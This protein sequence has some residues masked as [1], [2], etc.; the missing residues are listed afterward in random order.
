MRDVDPIRASK[1]TVNDR[2]RGDAALDL[3]NCF[4]DGEFIC[5]A[6]EGK[7]DQLTKLKRELISL[8]RDTPY[9]SSFIDPETNEIYCKIPPHKDL[10]YFEIFNERTLHVLVANSYF[11]E[12]SPFGNYI[13][14]TL[15]ES[16]SKDGQGS[17][18]LNYEGQEFKS[19]CSINIPSNLKIYND[20]HPSFF[21]FNLVDSKFKVEKIIYKNKSIELNKIYNNYCAIYPKFR[22]D[23]FVSNNI[24]FKYYTINKFVG[25]KS[26]LDWK[27]NK[28]EEHHVKIRSHIENKSTFDFIGV[29]F[30]ERLF[31]K[32]RNDENFDKT[33]AYIERNKPKEL[34]K[35]LLIKLANTIQSSNASLED[36]LLYVSNQKFISNAQDFFKYIFD[37][38]DDPTKLK[39]LIDDY[40]LFNENCLD[41]EKEN[42]N[43][44]CMLD[45]IVLENYISK[46]LLLHSSENGNFLPSIDSQSGEIIK[47]NVNDEKFIGWANSYVFWH[48]YLYDIDLIDIHHVLNE[49]TVLAHNIHYHEFDSK[50]I[51]RNKDINFLENSFFEKISL[52]EDVDE[53]NKRTQDIL[54]DA[55]CNK[56]WTIPYKAFLEIKFGNF[57]SIVFSENKEIIYF[58]LNH[59]SG[60]SLYGYVDQSVTRDGKNK[61]K[62][63]GLRLFQLDNKEIQE[64]VAATIKLLIAGFIRDWW[65]VELRQSVF[66]Y[67]ETS[68]KRKIN[69]KKVTEKIYKYIPRVKYIRPPNLDKIK[70]GFDYDSRREHQVTSH[71][72]FIGEKKAADLQIALAETYGFKITEGYTFV[73][74]YE[75]GVIKEKEIVW[76]ARSIQKYLYEEDIT[77]KENIDIPEWFKF[78]MDIKEWLDREGFETLH[79]GGK[80]DGEKDV[81]AT[82][83]KNGKTKIYLIQCKCVSKPVGVKDVRALGYE[84]LKKYPKNSVGIIATTNSFTEGAINEADIN[85]IFLLDKYSIFKELGDI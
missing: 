85:N 70:K 74:G 75:R 17:S 16:I 50:Y 56:I 62:L 55:S 32:W 25:D 29:G 12:S 58:T 81:F 39:E 1:I 42:D 23:G 7:T 73:K 10:S 5:S 44:D 40:K 21:S 51:D 27:K 19:L 43:R 22:F 8:Y 57:N 59:N 49:G 36:N 30:F 54:N 78:E 9:Y 33:V 14:I 76:R 26:Y 68:K 37:I 15:T 13:E 80:G 65:V 83:T 66:K 61:W 60:L 64:K 84:L 41:N 24:L 79:T 6:G 3:M 18:E 52:I 28:D 31:V 38:F 48:A 82:K 34:L 47:I 4:A 69:G 35:N 71:K 46:A 77:I 45:V 63:E 53:V 11:H 67:V 2:T 72:R 20:F